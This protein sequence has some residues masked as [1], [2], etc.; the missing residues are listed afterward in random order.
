VT[1]KRGGALLF[2]DA[3]TANGNRIFVAVA[4]GGDS[5]RVQLMIR[6]KELIAAETR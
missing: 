1:L 5:D 3:I 2:E 4:S 6:G